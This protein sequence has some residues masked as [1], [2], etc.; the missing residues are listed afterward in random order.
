[1]PGPQAQPPARGQGGGGH[2]GGPGAAHLREVL[3]HAAQLA[4]EVECRGVALGRVLGQAPLDDPPRRGR[5]A[6]GPGRQGVRLVLDDRGQRLD[7]ALPLERRPPAHHLVEHR[8]EGELVGAMVHWPT[9]RLLGRHVPDRAHDDPGGGVGG[10]LH[11]GPGRHLRDVLAGRP[12]PDAPVAAQLGEAE[13]E[14]L[15][16]AVA[17]Q[18]DV[19]GLEVAGDDAGGVRPRE[20]VGQLAGDVEHPP[21]R[22]RELGA[23]EVA[24]RAPV[25]ELHHCEGQPRR[26]ADLVNRDDVGVVEGGGGPRLLSEAAKAVWDLGK[27][28]RQELDGDVAVEIV[29]AGA[30][31]LTH[32]PRAN[33]VEE[34]VP[35]EPHTDHGWHRCSIVVSRV[36]TTPRREAGSRWIAVSGTEKGALPRNQ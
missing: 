23:D 7:G 32:A 22:Q 34:L 21:G 36:H 8:A 14:D 5:E 20:P 9:A 4:G 10:A 31:N 28:F 11:V 12:I 6:G 3:A 27:G 19:L 1:M 15:H 17:R 26:L 16:V 25:H 18:H 29:V 33:L 2:G 13:V 24:Q 30:V 35:A